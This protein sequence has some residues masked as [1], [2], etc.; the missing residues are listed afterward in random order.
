MEIK[1]QLGFITIA[2][3]SKYNYLELAYLQAL[4]IKIVMPNSKYAVIADKPTIQDFQEKYWTVIDYVIPIQN[5]YAR[6]QD[7]KFNNEWQVYNLTPFNETIKLESDILITRDISHWINAF[8]TRDLVL[9]TGIKN[10]QQV[11]SDCRYY[12]QLFDINELPDV[13]NGLMYFKYSETE[14]A[15]KFFN[16]AREIYIH[17][18][19][20]QNVLTRCVN[21][22]ASTDLVYS[23][24][25]KIL[26][27]ENCTLP[28]DWIN[29]VHMK[30]AINNWPEVPWYKAVITEMDAPMIRIGNL[31]Q[32][33]PVH[34]FE[35]DWAKE[36]IKEYENGFMERTNKSF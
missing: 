4:S 33:H 23:L 26:G 3:N 27:V 31:N 13:Y 17:W 9:S 32:Y 36:I 11:N 1:D 7:Q 2:Q 22:P 25:A 35:K 24:A 15:L 20:I 5:D 14:T 21:V 29:F 34:Y 8:R 16:I 30:P 28:L 10:Y 18:D 6:N 19:K 12:R